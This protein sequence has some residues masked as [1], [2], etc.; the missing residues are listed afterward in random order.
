[1]VAACI[2]LVFNRRF[3]FADDT[4]A[5][6]YGIWVAIGRGLRDGS[7]PFFEPSRWMAGNYVAEGQWGLFNP[8]IW[9]I[10]WVASGSSDAVVVSTIVKIV[11]LG[12]AAGGIYLLAR[13]YR[14][15]AMWSAIG[16]FL[17]P[18]AGFTTYIDAASWVTS[19]FVWALLPWAWWGL[20]R[21]LL[22]GGNPLVPFV[23]GYFLVTVGYVHGTLMLCFVIAGVLLEGVV[24]RRWR[25]T[26]RVLAVGIALG[27]VAVAVY[28]PSILTA[29]VTARSDDEILN[30]NFMSPDLSGL[31]T[32]ATPLALP[33]MSGFWAPPVA[34]PL[35][36]VSWL[37]PL[38]VLVVPSR[39]W[40]V[41][42]Q[43]AAAGV[44]GVVASVLTFGPSDMGPLR[45]PA[46]VLPYLVLVIMIVVVVLLSRAATRPTPARIRAAVLLVVAG[47]AFAWFESPTWWK[48]LGL[49]VVL[50]GAGVVGCLVLMRRSPGS[51][52][53]FVGSVLLVTAAVGVAQHHYFPRSPLPDFGLP[54]NVAAY[55]DALAGVEGDVMTLGRPSFAGDWWRDT[56]Y[57]NAW[58][59]NDT[60]VVNVYS[61][62]AHQAF[63]EDLC[64]DPHGVVCWETVET[65]FETDPATGSPVADL[66]SLSAV[67]ILPRAD[68]PDD[69]DSVERADPFSFAEPPTGWTERPGDGSSRV[70]VRDAALPSA[71]GISWTSPGTEVSDVDVS[72]TT[73][74]FRVD[75]VPAGGGQVVLSRLDWPG[76]SVD[77]GEL[78]PSVRGYLLTV[79]VD[80]AAA[81]SVV[82][83]SF[84]PP[85]WT[86]GLVSIA[87]ATAGILVWGAWSALAARRRRARVGGGRAVSTAEEPLS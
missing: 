11:T 34:A 84:T 20:R 32:G 7:L 8:L 54:A 66:L 37:L 16:A 56:L 21:T 77:G 50:A 82:T 48:V 58:Y 80:D 83:V 70:W 62:V 75:S 26:V 14:A 79:D 81:G 10:G 64:V 86:I 13:S 53:W 61:P 23:A 6:A 85:G 74:R 17:T 29:P 51:R 67:Q 28:L 15:S 68:V 12:V 71:G 39:A 76:Y 69:V 45:F 40:P 60:T 30:T 42:R 36:Y 59:L 3:Y 33:W 27:L 2:P 65:L 57:A 5:G 43:M 63:S 46:R 78:A 9:L 73:V 31:A 25:D 41:L 44:V 35:M 18:L 4:Q 52:T 1:M 49:G 24:A 38:V 87:L 72:K 47:G 19:L 22:Q 55:E